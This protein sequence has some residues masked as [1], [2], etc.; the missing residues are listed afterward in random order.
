MNNQL[1]RVPHGR[2]QAHT[3]LAL[4]T[5]QY[6]T[7]RHSEIN[8]VISDGYAW[9]RY[10]WARYEVMSDEERAGSFIN[11]STSVC[12]NR[13]CA[14]RR[15]LPVEPPHVLWS[16]EYWKTAILLVQEEQCAEQERRKKAK[17]KATRY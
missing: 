10:S 5:C 9:C 12:P 1:A 7:R 17:V 6:I 16:K 15:M 4:R 11:G 14:M 13:C 3:L 2:E 8:K